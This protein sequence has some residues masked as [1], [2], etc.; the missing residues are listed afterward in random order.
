MYLAVS[1]TDV[2]GNAGRLS[3]AAQV[4]AVRPPPRGQPSAP[5]PCGHPEQDG[6]ATPPNRAGRATVCLE[7]I[8]NGPPSDMVGLR[9]EVARALDQTIIATDR[10]NWMVGQSAPGQAPAPGLPPTSITIVGVEPGSGPSRLRITADVPGDSETD[11]AFADGLLWAGGAFFLD[12]SLLRASGR[13]T[14]EVEAGPG[15]PPAPGQAELYPL[16]VPP[17][18]GFVAT[19][20][21]VW[22]AADLY[23]IALAEGSLATDALTGSL[24]GGCLIQDGPRQARFQITR[25]SAEGDFVLLV[26]PVAGDAPVSGDCRIETAPDYSRLS[27]K[28]RKLRQL[29]DK[30]GN[31]DAFGVVTGVPVPTGVWTFRDEIPGVGRSAFYYRVR[32]VDPAN[33]RSAWSPTSA[34]F[35]QVDSTP[36]E[37]P[38]DLRIVPGDRCVELRWTAPLDPRVDEYHVYRLDEV[39]PRFH[40]GMVA[41]IRVSLEATGRLRPTIVGGSVAIP[42]RVRATTAPGVEVRMLE[43]GSPTGPNLFVG[44]SDCT[45]LTDRRVEPVNPLVPDGTPVRVWIGDPAGPVLV[46]HRPGSGEPLVV[47]AGRIDLTFGLSVT[48]LEAVFRAD[49]VPESADL[50]ALLA[51]PAPRELAD[52][53]RDVA[54]LTVSGLG[55]LFGDGTEVVAIVRLSDGTLRALRRAP[56]RAE[57]LRVEGGMVRLD[58]DV[59]DDGLLR[60]ERAGPDDGASAATAGASPDLRLTRPSELLADPGPEG[61]AV[62]ITALNPLAPD[63]TA[64][65]VTLLDDG[66]A[67]H[68]FDGDAGTRTWRETGLRGG[69][70]Y[71][72]WLA[73]T[74]PLYPPPD[75]ILSGA[76]PASDPDASNGLAGT[77][78]RSQA[79]GPV[80]AVV[81]DRSVPEPPRLTGV[82]W[83]VP[84]GAA[85]TGPPV[86][87]LTLEAPG[88]ATSFVRAQRAPRADGPWSTVSENGGPGWRA[89]PAGAGTYVLID[90]GADPIAHRWYRAQL[91]TADDRVSRP[92]NPVEAPMPGGG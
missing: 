18:A 76:G 81:L 17:V 26:R 40:P 30:P 6:Y 29:A 54:T 2:R 23:R 87:R 77:R 59:P 13:V 69:R 82:E 56:G 89:W 28:P 19:I 9:F 83:A 91:R 78:L 21:S 32:A 92:G 34:P 31:E 38:R 37:A 22:P 10:R 44:E 65:T 46:T 42:G 48:A 49:R 72:Y 24:V 3:S 5:F 63:G 64:V 33:N 45:S 50:E 16:P 90:A 61:G 52:A 71:S 55:T 8:Y 47:Q 62:A 53:P 85:A 66:G 35:W 84:G 86:G 74:R 11:V 12:G 80:S 88:D 20:D 79:A 36:P 43:G 41:P 14:F 51:A 67:A 27:G 1:S 15:G 75:P 39:P 4:T 25:A 58:L 7:W 73:A 60:V 68:R 57:P 70:R